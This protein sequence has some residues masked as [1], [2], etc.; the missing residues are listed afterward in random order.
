MYIPD[1]DF[2]GGNRMEAILS[3]KNL[4]KSFGSRSV[5]RNVSFDVYGGEIF[6]FLGPNGAGKTTTIKMIMGFLFPDSGE[7]SICNMNLKKQYEKAMNLVGGIVENPE[8]YKEM[9][10]YENLRM[11]A[12]LHDGVTEARIQEVVA[13][14]GMQ[15]RAGEKLKKYS[16]GMKQRI[17]LAQAIVHKP[18]LLI[19]D[20]PTNGLDP[21]GI[22]E[23]RDI[24]K[25]LA[26]EENIAVFV[27][28]HMLAEME[29]MCDRVAIIDRGSVIDIK[30]IEE[31]LHMAS[32]QESYRFEVESE[33]VLK[34]KELAVKMYGENSLYGGGNFTD[35][36]SVQ[37][38]ISRDKIPEFNR[39]LV[40]N[41]ISVYAISEMENSL[42][43]AFIAITGG[44]ISIA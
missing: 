5:I 6:G 29:L 2:K 42:E 19:L 23:L 38:I 30:P 1:S 18:K 43:D 27:S 15:N 3:V 34:A 14:V 25:K 32:Q 41:G 28:S 4:N 17:G 40:E 21:A 22:K 7:I 16:L 39:S 26:H 33:S 37:L 8:M 11:Y 35:D 24:L 9:T 36:H 20:E 44:G 31:I 13:L 10:G 12:R